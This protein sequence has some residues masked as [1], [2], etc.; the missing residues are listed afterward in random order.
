VS[1]F[2]DS[3]T[4]PIAAPQELQDLNTNFATDK[5]WL[6]HATFGTSELASGA[7]TLRAV[8]TDVSG[9]SSVATTTFTVGGGGASSLP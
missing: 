3:S 1:F 2:L 7:H 5:K 6:Y 4:S 9:A 8:A